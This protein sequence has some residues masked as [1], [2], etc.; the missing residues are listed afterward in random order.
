MGR[1]FV[2]DGEGVDGIGD[3]EEEGGGL[4]SLGDWVGV[5]VDDD[6]DEYLCEEYG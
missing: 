4:D 6:F 3:E 5:E 2:D 1:V